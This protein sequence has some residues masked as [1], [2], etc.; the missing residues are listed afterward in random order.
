M[1]QIL[2]AEKLK[3]VH[4][5]IRG[6]I[7][8][9][10][11]RMRAAGIDVLRLNTGNPA[12]FGFGIPASVKNAL[13]ENVDKAAAY[14]DLRGMP[15]AREAIYQY[16]LKKNLPNIDRD[17]IF[18]GNG[19]S[20]LV[21]MALTALL[22][23][24]DEILIP[25]PDYSLWTN[26]AYI[27]GGTPVHYICDEQSKWYPD[28]ADIRKKITSRTKAILI[29]NP[30]NPTGAVYP[31]EVLE[32]IAQI[33]REHDLIV[34][35]DEIYDRLIM[36]G[37]PHTS[38]GEL[39]PD[40]FCVTFNGL[41]KSHIVCGFRCG[42]MIMSGNKEKGRDYIAGL[43]ALAAMRLCSNALMQLVIPAAL[44]DNESTQAML[45]PGGRLYEQRE[46][47]CK[48]L[49]EIEGITYVKNK[50]AFYLFPKLDVKR[51]NIT[52]DKQFAFDY[53][54][55]KHVMII[56]GSGFN[57]AQPDHFR[58]VMLPKPEALSAAMHAL[59]DFLSTYHQQG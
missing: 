43:V 5:D 59:G 49:D 13:L 24:G 19:V 36:D 44:A 57:W 55:E 35:S 46:A 14:C 52:N 18:V 56:P 15:A 3:Y 9:E 2:R 8:E 16:H 50:A 11:N 21:S 28:L 39:C 42:W 31:R 12:T 34:F 30:N 17:D 54:H 22:N 25:S 45:V 7:F 29:I 37:V 10:A 53:L 47:C 41:S 6:P 23:E 26:S 51:F 38:I 33:A 58:I 32:Q 1:E 27:A 20:E 4:S 48:A 40:L